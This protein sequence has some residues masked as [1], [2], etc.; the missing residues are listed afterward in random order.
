MKKAMDSF[1]SIVS[2]LLMIFFI[3]AI[4]FGSGWY[5]CRLQQP[6]KEIVS[7]IDEK[8][9]TMPFET[10][11]ETITVSEVKSTLKELSEFSTY[12]CVYT[13]NHGKDLSR[14]IGDDFKIPGT[15]NN[16][17]LTCDGIVKV[18]YDI[19]DIGVEVTDDTIL[20]TLPE[21][22]TVNDNYIIWDTVEVSE[23]NNILNP[24]A[25]SQYETL[26]SEIEEMGLEQ[27]ESKGIYDKA[28]ENI[29]KIIE[30][31]LSKFNNYEIKYK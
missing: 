9:L 10:K 7:D 1:K 18:G 28:E 27:A 12:E 20:I 8:D 29:K 30:G 11:S 6:Q 15:T 24:I 13:V 14:F 2:G 4:G 25:F 26:I 22:A 31:F 5:V 16:V 19:N 17:T 23:K 21:K 3:G